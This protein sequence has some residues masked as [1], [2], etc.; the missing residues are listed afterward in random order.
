MFSCN[1]EEADYRIVLH[2]LLCTQDVV[3]VAKDTDVL[4]LLIWAYSHFNVQYKWYFS[5]EK[6]TYSDISIICEFLGKEICKS[7]L[8]FHA[9]TG[10]DTT[11]YMF[12]VGKKR[13]FQ[14]LLKQSDK[15]RLLH[16]LE[17][18]QP[19]LENDIGDLKTF[20]QTVMYSGKSSESYV[21]TRINLY[22]QQKQKTSANLPPDPDSLLQALR[23]VQL[24]VYVWRRLYEIWINHVDPLLYGWRYC[25]VEDMLLPVWFTGNQFPQ[26]LRRKRRGE[27]ATSL[28]TRKRSTNDTDVEFGDGELSDE[29]L[30]SQVKRCKMHTSSKANDETP[31]NNVIVEITTPVDIIIE[32]E[33]ANL[34]EG[35][36]ESVEE[37]EIM[38]D[39]SEWELSDFNSS[40]DSQSDDDWAP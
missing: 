19:L 40:N 14:K 29:I 23:R 2:A 16:A 21:E 7:L 35:D 6:G 30:Q 22:K 9:I 15:C 11:S 8:S 36:V 20:V 37:S 17:K 32:E 39:E 27:I 3:V 5:Y 12:R 38:S 10:C 4:V 31:E 25:V 18:D 34:N 26:S 24:Q 13:V 1:H 28:S 33:A